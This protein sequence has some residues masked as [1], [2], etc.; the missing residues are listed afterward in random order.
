M[1][2]RRP[3]RRHR[4]ARRGDQQRGADAV[5]GAG[6]QGADDRAHPHR[7]DQ[8][9][10]AGGAGAVGVHGQQRQNRLEVEA[11]GA[12]VAVPRWRSSAPSASTSRRCCRSWPWIQLRRRGDR[13]TRFWSARRGWARSS[14][15]WG[16]PA[17]ASSSS[18]LVAAAAGFGA[19]SLV[20]SAAPTL[21]LAAVGPVVPLGA[22]TVT[23]AASINS[24][25][26][27]AAEPRCAAG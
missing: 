2:R 17:T 3:A 15:P 18:L 22:S 10:V 23:L 24:G 4:R 9:R 26:Q 16:A 21:A 5:A 20:A 11:E 6:G 13:A 1:R 25:L 12:D 14:A 19:L 8:Q 27:L 7:A